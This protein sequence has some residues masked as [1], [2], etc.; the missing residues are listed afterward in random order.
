MTHESFPWF[1]TRS[2]KPVFEG[3][4]GRAKWW[5]LAGR[6]GRG[7]SVWPST[8]P[9]LSLSHILADH[10]DKVLPLAHPKLEDNIRL[11]T[12]RPFLEDTTVHYFGGTP[13]FLGVHNITCTPLPWV[14]TMSLGVHFKWRTPLLMVYTM[15]RGVDYFGCANCIIQPQNDI[16]TEDPQRFT[17]PLKAYL[18]PKAR[19]LPKVSTLSKGICEVRNK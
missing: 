6:V 17:L 15:P 13:I 16:P 8:C 7:F 1:R 19:T 9:L 11:E 12:T 2:A 14:Y 5:K 18:F 10:N 4:S 3:R